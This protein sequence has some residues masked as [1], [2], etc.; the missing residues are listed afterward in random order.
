MPVA[1]WP[2]VSVVIPMR[3]AETTIG[4]QLAALAAQSYV[5]EWEVIVADNGSIDRSA[6]VARSWKGR[7]PALQVIDASARAG[8]PFARNLGVSL[9]A[10]DVVLMCDADDVVGEGWI[11]ALVGGLRSYD[12]A[13]GVNEYATL[14][15]PRVLEWH[16]PIYRRSATR[17]VAL[18]I[19]VAGG[20]GVPG[21]NF[22]IS[23]ALYAALGGYSEGLQ[24]GDA[25][26]SLRVADAGLEVG[27]VPEAV[28]AVRLRSDLRSAILQAFSR[29]GSLAGVWASNPG[30]RPRGLGLARLAAG[31]ATWLATRL[32]LA[33][34]SSATRGRWL[35]KA[36]LHVGWL[37]TRLGLRR[38]PA[39]A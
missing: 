13:R 34:V 3:D 29:G 25:D 23:A 1:R 32:P 8:S 27:T 15:S 11:T 26:F 21:G 10:G 24:W 19:F 39:A 30:F 14:N 20:I 16:K 12:V 7:I 2:S 36:A 5:G 35:I 38:S 6:E 17:P 28:V 4:E 37:S 33:V 18:E 9:A 31:S 22:A